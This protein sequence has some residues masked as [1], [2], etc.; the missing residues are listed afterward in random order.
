M[1][2]L[3]KQI[4]NRDFLMSKTTIGSNSPNPVVKLLK[5]EEYLLRKFY[6]EGKDL[7]NPETEEEYKDLM[8]T[9]ARF[10]GIKNKIIDGDL[11]V[12][13]GLEKYQFDYQIRS[14]IKK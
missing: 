1:I 11:H 8:V 2:I 3:L 6:L 4:S 5:F 9:F 10:I 13:L 14:R 12:S 7:N